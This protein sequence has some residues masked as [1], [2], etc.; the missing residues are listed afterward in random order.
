MTKK[1][2]RSAAAAASFS[3]KLPGSAA[4]DWQTQITRVGDRYN[5]EYRRESFDL[6]PEVEAMPIFHEWAAGTL[7]GKIASPFWDLMKPQKNQH[8]LD[9]GC[10]LSFLIYPCWREWDL[11]FH[12]Q[13]ISIVAQ[14]ALNSRGSQ[15]NSK[16]FKRVELSPAHQLSYENQQFDWA[17]ATGLSCYYPLDYWRVAIAEVKRVLKPEGQLLFDVLNP[18]APLAENWAILETY[19]GAEVFLEPLTAWTTLFQKLGLKVS[20]TLSGELFQLYRLRF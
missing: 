3:H 17:I 4:Q 2:D 1:S 13:E 7:A 20:A 18:D 16:L 8:C 12:G 15:L 11:Y 9:I 6:P 10:G 5:R 19:L 14:E